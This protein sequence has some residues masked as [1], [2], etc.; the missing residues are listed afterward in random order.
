ML[1]PPLERAMAAEQ[2]SSVTVTLEDGQKLK[3]VSPVIS[4]D[5]IAGVRGYR[6]DS[7][8]QRPDE[9]LAVALDQVAYAEHSTVSFWR[10]P[11]AAYLAAGVGLG[12]L[13]CLSGAD[14]CKG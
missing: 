2:P 3:L 8:G 10:T 9:R 7:E 1:E 11:G 4:E 12:L 5:T 14:A 13:L 6:L